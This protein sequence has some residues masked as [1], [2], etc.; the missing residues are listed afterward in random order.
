MDNVKQDLEY[1]TRLFLKA[2]GVTAMAVIALALGIGANTAIFS[3][4]NG[5]LLRPL[6]GVQDPDRLI[7]LER[8]V[9]GRLQY[10]FGYPD[11]IDYLQKNNTLDDLAA[12]C[13]TPLSF[14]NGSAERLRG[15]LVSGNYFAVL[16]VKPAL[17][18]LISPDDDVQIGGHPVAV[19]SYAMWLRSFGAD[20][21]VIGREMKLNGY[22]FTI[23]G[24]A[25]KEFS[26]T[27]T[28]NSYDV[29]IPLK[30]QVQAIPRTLGRHWFNDRTAGWMAVFGRLKPG[31]SAE[32]ARID[33]INIARALEQSYPDTNAGRSVTVVPGLGLN[34]D[35]RARF[36][37]FLALLLAVVLLLLLIACSNVANLLLLRAVSRQREIAVRLALGATRGR[38]VRQLL[39]EGLVLSVTAGAL[40][41]LL[42]PW[43]AEL[44]VNLQPAYGLR[45]VDFGLD[46]RVL[47]FT[48]ILSI[49][50]AVVFGLVP[51]F[52]SS[53]PDLITSL[54]DGAPTSDQNKSR[55]RNSLVVTQIGLSLILLIGA[56]LAVRTMHQ[57]LKLDRGFDSENMALMSMD[58][59][60]RGYSEAQG[61]AFYEDLLKRIDALPGVISSSLAKT[62]PPNDWSD[63]LSVFLPEEAPPPEIIRTG[64]DDAGLR[65]D[66]NRIAPNYFRTL[67][68]PLL[69]GREF[70]EQDRVGTTPVAIVNQR[71][72]T[73][74][75]P[76]EIATGKLLAVPFWREP[77]PLVQII[78]VARDTK[79]RSLLADMPL[80][81][82]LPE[83]QSYD[84]R[85]TLVARTTID[86]ATLIPAI[87]EEV[88]TLD[89]DL[90]L[91]SVKT[92]T[93]QIEST[94][95]QQRTAAGLIGIFGLLAVALA[96]IGIYGV[97]A[98]SVAQR[99]R[100]IGIRMALGADAAGVRGMI[101][102][103]GLALALV[104]VGF[105]TAAA[106]VL[107]RLMSSLLYEVSPTDPLT[108][109]AAS[110][111]LVGIAM[112]A[113][114][115]P[116]IR[117][118]KVD[119]MVALRCE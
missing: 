88:A 25:S 95:W 54:K 56:G 22:D 2:P 42:A 68:V 86:P 96:A 26:G 91:F 117:A 20:Q 101:L 76:G 80:L 106:F 111:A 61:R 13:G 18:R 83:L 63:R 34:S 30:M 45:G 40:G 103:Q 35:T 36:R 113:C 4:V 73:R 10:N 3:L 55:L 94:L 14:N 11:Y 92:M 23:V 43:T 49:S 1:A 67:G 64:L 104:G 81:I 39:T 60:I 28:G 5:A 77:R 62:V 89:K 9:N 48:V 33:L 87:R 102:R 70:T 107:T 98:H 31:V 59:T 110:A 52:Q 47:V 53:N 93:E 44:I 75:W 17:G 12:H 58:L 29:W 46:A 118:T 41:L 116:A 15:D 84:G 8:M 79:H 16:G 66:A 32:A 78:G 119:P 108:F 90:V 24:V 99:T 85:A 112:G 97:I 51:A 57:A 74:L 27:E 69:E 82:Y 37:N 100:E 105:G 72:A 19:L 114:L 6:P 71:L 21:D 7:T 109:F 38:L 65:V 115:I 50:T